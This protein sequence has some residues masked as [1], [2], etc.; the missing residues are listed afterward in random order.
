MKTLLQLCHLPFHLTDT[1]LV[2]WCT[3]DSVCDMDVVWHVSVWCM[4]ASC[5]LKTC[6]WWVSI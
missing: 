4:L 5:I 1:S 3:V 6:H 2:C